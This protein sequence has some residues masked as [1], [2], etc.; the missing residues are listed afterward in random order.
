MGGVHRRER[1]VVGR[2]VRDGYGEWGYPAGRAVWPGQF[3][4]PG[5]VRQEVHRIHLV[6]RAVVRPLLH[7]ARMPEEQAHPATAGS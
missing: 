1:P 6:D 2:R 5:I 3:I 7:V 4:G